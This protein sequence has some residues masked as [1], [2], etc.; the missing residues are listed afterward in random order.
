MDDERFLEAETVSDTGVFVS[1]EQ[2]AD[3]SR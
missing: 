3:A 2:A 1:P